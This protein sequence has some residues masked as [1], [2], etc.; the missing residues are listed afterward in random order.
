MVY[1]TN[2]TFTFVRRIYQYI[3]SIYLYALVIRSAYFSLNNDYP[4][5]FFLNYNK[6]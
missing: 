5:L 1:K 6:F 4:V 3:L 2:A